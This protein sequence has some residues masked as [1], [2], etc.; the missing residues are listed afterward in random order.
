MPGMDMASPADS[1]PPAEVPMNAVVLTIKGV[2]P[3]GGGGAE[4]DGGRQDGYE[5]SEEAGGLQDGD[6]AGT[7]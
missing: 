1:K 7:V 4:D 2:C 3:R 5:R 6:D